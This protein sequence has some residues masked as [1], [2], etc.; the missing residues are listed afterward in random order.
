MEVGPKPRSKPRDV[1]DPH[2]VAAGGRHHQPADRLDVVALVLAHPDLDRI[3]LA[4]LAVAGDLVLAADHQPQRAGQV[5]DPHAE[6]RGPLPID[7]HPQ[8]R[9]AQVDARLDVDEL[10]QCLQ[11][12]VQPQ[13]VAA[14]AS[15]GPAP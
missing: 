1:V 5:G 11:P 6:V 4:A 10:R 14:Q 3:A 9:V 13:R 2:R 7:R 12:L 8:L 15:A